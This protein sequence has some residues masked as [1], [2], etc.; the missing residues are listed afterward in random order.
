MQ[1]KRTDRILDEIF[2]NLQTNRPELDPAKLA[3]TRELMMHA[4]RD[5]LVRGYQPLEATLRLLSWRHSLNICAAGSTTATARE[6]A[7]E[8]R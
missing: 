2:T 5:C 6:T 8:K 7:R 4:V 1:A 3:R